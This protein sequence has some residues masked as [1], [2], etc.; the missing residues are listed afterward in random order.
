MRH[1]EIEFMNKDYSS[2]LISAFKLYA[3]YTGIAIII[4]GSG[5]LIGWVFDIPFLKSIHPDFVSMKANTALS[6]MLM[7]ISLFLL[8]RRHIGR[9]SC[10]ISRG[11]GFPSR[12]HWN[13]HHG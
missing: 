7:G 9:W 5:V 13:T 10:D 6:F 11:C 2:R 1:G 4:I 12:P 3:E 8:Q